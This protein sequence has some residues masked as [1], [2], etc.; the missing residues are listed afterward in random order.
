MSVPK[1]VPWG[2]RAHLQRPH[3]CP[4]SNASLNPRSPSLVAS[5]RGD[6]AGSMLPGPSSEQSQISGWESSE[7]RGTD[8]EQGAGITPFHLIFSLP[9]NPMGNNQGRWQPRCGQL[10]ATV[11]HQAPLSMGFSRQNYRSGGHFLLQ[12]PWPK[13]IVMKVHPVTLDSENSDSS[14]SPL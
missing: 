5:P 14:G 13:P 9:M 2:F 3:P 7:H 8:G 10:F 6:V 4:L 12:N 11:A 1:E